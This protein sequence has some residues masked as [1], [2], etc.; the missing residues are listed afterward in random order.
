MNDSVYFFIAYNT[1]GDWYYGYAYADTGTYDVGQYLYSANQDDDGGQWYYYVYSSYDFGYDTGY[2]GYSIADPAAYYYDNDTGHGASEFTSA[3]G[4]GGIGSESG[5]LTS[6]GDEFGVYGRSEADNDVEPSDS[7]YYFIAVNSGGDYYYG[8]TYADYGT[9]YIGEYIFSSVSDNDGGSWYYYVYATYDLGYE[10]GYEGT[11]YVNPALAYYDNDVGY[12]AAGYESYTGYYGIGSE[13][14]YLTASG[15]YFGQFGYFEADSA[16]PVDTLYYFIAWNSAGD[17]YY[18]FEYDDTGTYAVGQSWSSSVTDDDGGRWSYY[19]Y[20]AQ[21]LGYDTGVEGYSVV[22]VALPYYDADTGTA[23]YVDYSVYAGHDGIGSEYGYL[24]SSGDYF[25]QFGY[26]EADN[27]V[28]PPD[29]VY[30]FRA[31][32]T[33]GDYYYGYTYA[34][35]GTYLLGQSVDAPAYDNDGGLWSYY[36]YAAYDFGHDSNL[37]YYS[38]VDENYAYYDADTGYGVTDYD[39]FIGY[40]GLGSEHGMLTTSG[41]YFGLVDGYGYFEADN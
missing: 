29:S 40:G 13:Y 5:W 30:F 38:Y 6:N 12:G 23:V 16:S 21:D 18:G 27:D 19:V 10:T 7:A 35:T 17:Y 3:F 26:F 32:N 14:G 15:E 1:F 2:E 22:N 33:S 8:Y 37:Q 4:T 28:S 36:I 41:E 24:A 39:S 25:G 34:D 31:S 11:S 9:L 20:A